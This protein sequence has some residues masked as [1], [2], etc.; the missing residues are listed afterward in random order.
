M[1]ANRCHTCLKVLD[2]IRWHADYKMDVKERLDK[3]G[4]ER[5]CCRRMMLTSM[6]TSEEM[7][8]LLNTQRCLE[9][10]VLLTAPEKEQ[11]FRRWFPNTYKPLAPLPP[12][13]PPPP[14]STVV[15]VARTSIRRI[16]TCI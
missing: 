8:G 2:W 14:P 6:D 4:Y 15:V 7:L 9:R 16:H 3:H 12:P 13:P 11:L 10:K 1:H 5:V